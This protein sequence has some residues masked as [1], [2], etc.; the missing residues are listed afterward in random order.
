MK[1]LA[2]CATVALVLASGASAT[3]STIYPGVGIGRVKLGMTKAQVVRVLG[4]DYIVNGQATVGDAAYRE[5]AWNFASWSVGFLRR[6]STWRAIQV[7]TTLRPQRT[8][9][10][11]GVG[12]PFKRV[13]QRHTGV[14]CGSIDPTYGS[15]AY[16]DSTASILV[17]KGPVYTAFAVEPAQRGQ[18]TGPWR[19]Y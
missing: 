12:S 13:A 6:G 9:A 10:G 11:I 18:Y 17:N 1:R 2:A 8:P 5:L 14:F 3:E 19:V 4:K 7:E 16:G 15:G